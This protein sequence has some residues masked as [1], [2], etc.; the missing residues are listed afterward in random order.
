MISSGPAVRART[1]YV[2]VLMS[3]GIPE[4]RCNAGCEDDKNACSDGRDNDGDGLIDAADPDCANINDNSLH[5]D[6]LYGVCNTTEDFRKSRAPGSYVDMSGICPAYNQPPQIMARIAD[7]LALSDAYS[8]GSVTLNTVLLFADQ[9]AVNAVCPNAGPQFG[10]DHDQAKALLEAMAQAGNGTFRDVNLQKAD[11][12]FL[13]FNFTSLS[14]Q[15][16]LTEMVARDVNEVPTL[17]GPIP[18]S[19]ADG[20]SDDEENALGTDP[21]NPDTDG[22][23]YSDLFEVRYSGAGFDPLDPNAP[24]LNCPSSSDLDGDG[25]DDCEENFLGT[26]PRL[27]DSDG[28]RL[29][30]GLELVEHTDP[31]TADALADPDF[32][33][34]L[35][36]EEIRAGTLPLVPDLS[37]YRTDAVRYSLDDLGDKTVVNPDTGNKELRRCYDFG[38]SHLELVTTP[39]TK[40]RGRNRIILQA[41]EEPVQLVGARPVATEACVEAFYDGNTFKDPPS[42]VVDST[43]SYWDN[44]RDAFSARMDDIATA[45][46]KNPKSFNR[47]TLEQIMNT[48]LP[49]RPQVGDYLYDKADLKKLVEKYLTPNLNANVP[50]DAWQIFHPMETFDP[51]TDC[52]RPWEIGRLQQLFRTIQDACAKCGGGP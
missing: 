22:D 15:Y 25:L 29:T 34:I 7:L 41:L 11:D 40:E 10:Y 9:A 14:S 47:N 13:D 5:P 21:F 45:C 42:G 24:A 31:T 49:A 8:A 33:G 18:D 36:R 23:H 26:D 43:Q 48:C 1:K 39:L 50:T 19:D 30:D 17:K 32:D 46:G 37:R 27:P 4:P 16:W 6:N 38:V 35:N 3:D 52:V 28:D 44:L 2:V 51:A 12:T 20:L